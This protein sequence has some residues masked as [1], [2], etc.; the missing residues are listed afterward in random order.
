M[1][2]SCTIEMMNQLNWYDDQDRDEM[3]ATRTFLEELLQTPE[4]ER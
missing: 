1:C 4:S 2:Q 3:I